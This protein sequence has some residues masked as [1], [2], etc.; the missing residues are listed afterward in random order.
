M[1]A[2]CDDL[3]KHYVRSDTG[4]HHH[5][6]KSPDNTFSRPIANQRW[7]EHRPAAYPPDVI[8][9]RR[10]PTPTEIDHFVPVEPACNLGS[11]Q[12][13]FQ[14]A[15]LDGTNSELLFRIVDYAAF[16]AGALQPMR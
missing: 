3:L 11:R 5:A 8:A 14:I 7:Y 15:R 13:Q 1:A 9:N 10:Q 16:A 12:D 4:L 6:G 2:H